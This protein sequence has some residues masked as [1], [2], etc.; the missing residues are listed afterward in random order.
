MSFIAKKSQVIYSINTTV[1]LTMAE[2]FEVTTKIKKFFSDLYKLLDIEDIALSSKEAYKQELKRGVGS[3]I[4]KSLFNKFSIEDIILSSKEAY[5]NELK[6]GM[7][8]QI[9]KSLFNKFSI[10]EILLSSKESFK[11]EL[12]K[13][14]GSQIGK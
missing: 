8:L 7:G 3:E 4:G 6:K 14:V 1:F 5:K 2:D 10:N 12:K 11:N 9:G 13:G